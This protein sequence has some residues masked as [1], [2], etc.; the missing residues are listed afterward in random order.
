MQTLTLSILALLLAGSAAQAAERPVSI[1]IR[2]GQIQVSGD[3]EDAAGTSV[4]VA[5]NVMSSKAYDFLMGT[6]FW[7]GIDTNFGSFEYE[8]T[9]WPFAN[10]TVS[11][12]TMGIT[13]SVVFF[14]ETPVQLQLGLAITRIALDQEADG[15]GDGDD[16]SY[17]QTYGTQGYVVR[18]GHLMAER[19]TF[20]AEYEAHTV[21]Q[22]VADESADLRLNFVTATVGWILKD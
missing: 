18:I 1:G 21:S 9:D 17:A 4:G 7:M 11:F 10:D 16:E 3:A 8:G 20:S 15:D 2:V 12:S 6:G 22:V 19:V 14:T 13:P 5:V